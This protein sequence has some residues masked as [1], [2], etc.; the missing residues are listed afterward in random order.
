MS[1]HIEITEEA[2]ADLQRQRRN[3][4]AT[5]LSLAVLSIG[6]MGLGLWALKSYI[7]D[8]TQPEIEAYVLPGG[9]GDEPEQVEITPSS[10]TNSSSAQPQAAR[11]IASTHAAPI[12]K[13]V[14]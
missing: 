8:V 9:A 14:T 4:T 11:I 6:I 5:S 13:M 7:K 1:L 10:N 2:K 3:Q 12:I